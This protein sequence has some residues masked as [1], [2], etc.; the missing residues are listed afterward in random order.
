MAEFLEGRKLV[1]AKY[2]Y[3]V[4][5]KVP[6]GVD[7]EDKSVVKSWGVGRWQGDLHIQYVDGREETIASSFNA[8]ESGCGDYAKDAESETICDVA[9]Y[10]WL[11]EDPWTDSPKSK[12]GN[13]PIFII[14]L[15]ALIFAVNFVYHRI[16]LEPTESS[17]KSDAVT[18]LIHYFFH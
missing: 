6:K 4:V 3:E 17:Q 10:Q 8:S 9:E 16:F 2:S 12:S 14:L 5:Y 13:N 1:V 18:G 11:F 15:F 7:L